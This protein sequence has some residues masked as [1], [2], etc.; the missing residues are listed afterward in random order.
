MSISASIHPFIY[1][2][3][4]IIYMYFKETKNFAY[5]FIFG[6]AESLLLR[7]FLYSCSGCGY[8]SLRCMGSLQWLLSLQSTGSM[9]RGLQQL[10]YTGSVAPWHVGSSWIRDRTRVAYIDGQI[11]YH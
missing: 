3:L 2:S 11:L 4:Y 9:A 6:C 7:L 5:L 1:F 10:W 8:S